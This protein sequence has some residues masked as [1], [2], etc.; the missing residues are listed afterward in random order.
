MPRALEVAMCKLL[1]PVYSQLPPLLICLPLTACQPKPPAFPSA[2]AAQLG[3]H[4][5]RLGPKC[6]TPKA[7]SPLQPGY[8]RPIAW[9]LF[10]GS[11]ALLM[12]RGREAAADTSHPATAELALHRCPPNLR[13]HLG[14]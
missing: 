8:S 12:S 9:V 11:T 4:L 14:G 7:C 1:L 5:W 3:A 10:G 13:G 2:P 6:P